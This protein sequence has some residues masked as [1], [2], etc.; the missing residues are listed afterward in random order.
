[1]KRERERASSI[2]YKKKHTKQKTEKIDDKIRYVFLMLD[3]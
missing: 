2:F 1:M 3:M